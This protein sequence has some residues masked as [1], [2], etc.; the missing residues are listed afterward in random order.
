MAPHLHNLLRVADLRDEILCRMDL[1]SLTRLACVSFKVELRSVILGGHARTP[2]A[3]TSVPLASAGTPS[4]AR[5]WRS[6][7]AGIL[8]TTFL[9]N[10]FLNG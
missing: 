7:P 3:C 2:S 8:N 4:C 5:A 9:G 6:R 10:G 1:R